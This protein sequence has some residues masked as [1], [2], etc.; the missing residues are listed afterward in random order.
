MVFH[1]G[2]GRCS[3]EKGSTAI[4]MGFVL[5][6]AM[7]PSLEGGKQLGL[8]LMQSYETIILPDQKWLDQETLNLCSWTDLGNIGFNTFVGFVKKKMFNCSIW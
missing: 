5:T 3:Q 8:C 4:R 6:H 2:G 7:D 1:R